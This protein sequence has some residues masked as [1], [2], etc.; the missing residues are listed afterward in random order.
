M[1]TVPNYSTPQ[2]APQALPGASI[3]GLG[4]RALA[5]DTSADDLIQGGRAL[6]NLGAQEI[7]AEAREQMLANQVRVDA[8]LNEVRAAQ[9][10]LTFDPVDGYSTKTG[11]AALDPDAEGNGLSDSYGTKL[12]ESIDA[13]S[14]G[15]AN[16]AQQRVFGAQAAAL[17][18]QFRGQVQSHVMKEYQSFG[19]Q[20]QQGTIDLATDA[21]LKQ[22]NDPTAIDAQV[23][24][25]RA[26]VWKAGQIAG[27]PA[28]LVEA[29][30]DK[31]VSNIHLGVVSS[32]VENNNPEYAI[33]YLNAYKKDMS[34]NDALKAQGLVRTDMTARV[35]TTTATSAMTKYRAGFAPTDM[36]RVLAITANTESRNNPNAVGPYIEGQGT[37]KGSMQVMDATNRD[38]G[39]GVVPAK[40]DSPAERVRVGS[41]YMAAM[42]K[43]YGG[44]T[45]QA[46]AAYNAGPGTVDK[47]IKK[48]GPGGDWLAAM[49][50]FQTPENHAQ[51]VKYVQ[52]N[53]QAYQAGGGAPAIPSLQDVHD[54]IRS[55]LPEGTDPKT[56]TAALAEGTRMYTDAINDRKV[57]GENAVQE[58]QRVLIQ[59]G[60]NFGNLP[61]EMKANVTNFAP[62]QYDQ[63]QTFAKAI[64]EPPIKSNMAAYHTALEH[65]EELAAMP[66]SAF[67]NFVMT[68]FSPSDQKLVAK[69]REEQRSG[70]TDASAGAFNT[71]AFNS[72]VSNRLLSLGINPQPRK[73]DLAAQQQIGTIQKFLSDGVLGQQLQLGRKMTAQEISEFVDV[74]FA[75][76]NTFK[77]TF[78]GIPMGETTAP[79]LNMKVSD[80]PSGDLTQIKEAL[81]KHGN[82]DP[83][84]DQVL[85]TYWMRN[86]QNG[87]K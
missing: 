43:E 30:M 37:A 48:A 4:Q 84:D 34:A 29:K 78:I 25:A 49:A 83:S 14:A 11:A 28:N 23:Q 80:I 62:G 63:L 27:D 74:Q 9:Q 77:T 32:A 33:N 10:K 67:N 69:M 3:S 19:L 61:P 66:D 31:V 21:A 86:M 58:A 60:G 35:A 7:N 46:W 56:L 5:Q 36:D 26:A 6:Q 40:D 79:Y 8:A 2:V 57:Q 45:A 76:N 55:S 87:G 73:T 65:P 44:N 75:K 54:N 51:T 64:A 13:A 72:V 71:A 39:Y 1:P 20:T 52:T 50:D 18:T 53:Q 68:N 42:I 12:Q 85:R 24:S 47:A 41:D 70:K 15:L 16:P 17:Q 22:W 38:P 81:A 59:N 82:P